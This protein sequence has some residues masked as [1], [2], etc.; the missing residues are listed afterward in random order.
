M[1]QRS[2]ITQLPSTTSTKKK[3]IRKKKKNEKKRKRTKKKR[4]IYKK[5]NDQKVNY[6][7]GERAKQT[8]YMAEKKNNNNNIVANGG[9]LL[10]HTI[11]AISRRIFSNKEQC[12]LLIKDYNCF[13]TAA[14]D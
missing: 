10:C 1:T 7:K 9:P 13:K 5:A 11:K 4:K 3:K 14:T 12:Q 2:K 8:T 6:P